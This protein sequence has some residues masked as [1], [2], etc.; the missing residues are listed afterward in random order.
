MCS[1]ATGICPKKTVQEF[2]SDGWFKTGDYARIDK[3]GRVFIVGRAKDLVISG[4]YNVYPKEV[5]V[6]LDEINSVVE[7]AV[8]GVPHPDFGEGVTAAI[9]LESGVSLTEDE[10]KQQ[11]AGRIAK[12]KQPKTIKLVGELLRNSM[13]EVQKNVLREKFQ[14]LYSQST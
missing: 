12:F 2:T 7:A 13:G 8:F 1:R 10:I 4:G 5:E 11:I 14:G 3:E 9:V 6:L